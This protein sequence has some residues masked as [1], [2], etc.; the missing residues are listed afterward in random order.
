VGCTIALTFQEGVPS[1]RC[2]VELPTRMGAAA[3]SV[4][5]GGRDEAV[6]GAFQRAETALGWLGA[7]GTAGGG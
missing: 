7:S 5:A 1:W 6:A 4:D 3:V 2:V